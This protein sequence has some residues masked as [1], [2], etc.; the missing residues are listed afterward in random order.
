[1]IENNAQHKKNIK[2]T[3][4]LLFLVAIGVIL[5]IVKWVVFRHNGW[6][7]YNTKELYDGFYQGAGNISGDVQQRKDMA[8]CFVDKIIILY[9]EGVET[10]SADTLKKVIEQVGMECAETITKLSWTP[11]TEKACLKKFRDFKEL[12]GYSEEKKTSYAGC[13]LAKL[14]E[15]YPKGLMTEISQGEMDSLYAD[16]LYVLK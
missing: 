12:K 3:Y 8:K 7:A 15:K 13:L 5:G 11:I 2:V 4:L 14:K 1:M 10:I 9:P 6:N 16:C